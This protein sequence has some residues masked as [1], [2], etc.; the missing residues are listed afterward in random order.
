MKIRVKWP[1]VVILKSNSLTTLGYLTLN[2]KDFKGKNCFFS[3]PGGATVENSSKKNYNRLN[4]I[5]PPII[6]SLSTQ[7]SLKKFKYPFYWIDHPSTH[8]FFRNKTLIF[9]SFIV[10]AIIRENLH[11]ILVAFGLVFSFFSPFTHLTR[12]T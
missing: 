12:T 8:F 6:F 1:K 10:A 2:Q 3:P 4:K 5:F 9:C 11:W 7:N